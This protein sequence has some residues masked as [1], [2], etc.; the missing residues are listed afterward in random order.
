MKALQAAWEAARSLGDLVLPASCPGCD[1]HGPPRGGLCE[2]C[3]RAMLILSA[4]PYCPRCGGSLGPGVPSRPDGCDR[5]PTQLPPYDA[6]VRLGPYADPI[7]SM[8]R[9]LKYDRGPSRPAWLGALLA[10]RCRAELDTDA[11]DAVVPVPMHWRRR[12]TRGVDH[13]AAIGRGVAGGLGLSRRALL[14]RVRHTPPQ[15]RRSRTRRLANVRGAVAPRCRLDGLR[16]LLVDDVTTSGAT[17]GEAA[18]A[19]RRAGAE[20]V[21]LAVLAKAEPPR[22]YHAYLPAPSAVD[23]R[24]EPSQGDHPEERNSSINSS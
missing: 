20:G 14:R 21:Y 9:N 19:C 2:A 23:A 11:L 1:A 4:V 18:R 24:S 6:V 22:A 7:K 12:L 13:A 10:A 15:V 5:C 3:D 17:A 16:V 8:V